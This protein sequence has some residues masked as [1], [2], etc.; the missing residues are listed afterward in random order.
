[1]AYVHRV[2]TILPNHH[3][4]VDIDDGYC[5]IDGILI[6]PLSL[7]QFIRMSPFFFV[8]LSLLHLT[9]CVL[10]ACH[11]VSLLEAAGASGVVLEDQKRPRKCGHLSG[12]QIMDMEDYIIKLKK[13]LATR[14]NMFVIA[15]TDS[16]DPEVLTFTPS[17]SHPLICWINRISNN[18]C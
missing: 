7:L 1:M 6:S 13:V 18:V 8:L 12:K 9:C 14:T 10:V 11:V 5:D 15:R 3:I 17:L 16:S 4:L 2:R